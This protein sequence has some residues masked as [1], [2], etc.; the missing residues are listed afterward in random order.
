MLPPRASPRRRLP[1]RH[2]MMPAMAITSRLAATPAMAIHA[3]GAPIGA[4][5]GIGGKGGDGGLA[6]GWAGGETGGGESGC[7]GNDGE[8]GGAD[9]GLS[10]AGDGGGVNCPLRCS[11]PLLIP[12]AIA[13]P[14]PEMRP[15]I[16]STTFAPMSLA[17]LCRSELCAICYRS[18][19]GARL[20]LLAFFTLG[21]LL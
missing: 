18:P 9:G 3:G 12:P 4:K 10:G 8:G 19:R 6:G 13:P 16:P 21:F 11:M 7:G 15:P 17:W 14:A 5:G 1:A 2:T 20:C